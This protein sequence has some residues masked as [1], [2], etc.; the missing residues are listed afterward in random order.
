MTVKPTSDR[1]CW[2]FIICMWSHQKIPLLM[3]LLTDCCSLF[4]LLFKQ[5]SFSFP[6]RSDKPVPCTSSITFRH[7]KGP[8]DDWLYGLNRWSTCTLHLQELLGHWKPTHKALSTDFLCSC[9]SLS[10]RQNVGDFCSLCLST[11]QPSSVTLRGL[12]F[13]GWVAVV[14]EHFAV[15]PL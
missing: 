8:N 15:I 9:W 5:I 4:W 14:P 3:Q 7:N 11:R 13:H 12:S 2:W 1:L 6:H 10:S